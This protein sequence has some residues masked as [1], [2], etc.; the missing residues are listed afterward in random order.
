MH[1]NDIVLTVFLTCTCTGSQVHL[2]CISTLQTATNLTLVVTIL[3]RRSIIRGQVIADAI[4]GWP[5]RVP[6]TRYTQQDSVS[7]S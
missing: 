1:K 2:H 7:Y 3:Q 4:R 6:P 5:V